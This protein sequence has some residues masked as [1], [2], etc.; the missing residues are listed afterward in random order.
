MDDEDRFTTTSWNKKRVQDSIVRWRGP[1]ERWPLNW[2]EKKTR[3]QF[4][5]EARRIYPL[6]KYKI[7][8]IAY[9]FE[10]ERFSIKI[11]FLFV[12]HPE[13]N[14]IEMVWGRVR[15]NVDRRNLKFRLKDVE[16][17]TKEQIGLITA[18]FFKKIS[19]SCYYGSRQVQRN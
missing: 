17:K 1:D 16:A 19:G 9:E 4:L 18:E 2:K 12:A 8:K 6:P 13:L 10:T 11:L 15:G 7:Q 5:T 14:P 3:A